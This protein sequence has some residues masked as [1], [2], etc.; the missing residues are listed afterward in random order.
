M[1][2][3]TKV[4]IFGDCHTARIYSHHIIAN[5]TK[6]YFAPG[7]WNKDRTIGDTDINLK[8]WGLSGYKC[9][10]T[11]FNEYHNSNTLCSPQEDLPELPPITDNLI[12]QFSFSE[13]KS[14]DIVMPWL[15]YIDCR[16]WLPKYKNTEEVVKNYVEN[17]ISFFK[18]SEIRFIEPFPQFE[19]LGTQNYPETYRYDLKNE[20][21][22][23]FIEMLHKY[24]KKHGLMAPVSQSIVYDAV[25]DTRLGKRHVRLGGEYQNYTL[26][27]ALRPEYNKKIYLSLIPEIQKTVD[28]YKSIN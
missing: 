24:S 18:E 7:G 14:A 26:L 19:E 27:D 6:N 9:W 15:G 1:D 16:N 10:G 13:I 23:I 11:D 28:F 25:E 8:M 2:I 22:D 5:V 21:N 3:N 4:Y 17:T 12:D 20:Q